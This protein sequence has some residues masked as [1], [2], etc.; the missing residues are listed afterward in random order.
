MNPSRRFL[1]SSIL[2]TALLIVPVIVNAANAANAA[3]RSEEALRKADAAWERRRR[4]D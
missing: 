3:S 1:S 4:P 2:F